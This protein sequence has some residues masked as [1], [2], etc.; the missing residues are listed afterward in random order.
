L[1]SAGR[2]WDICGHT[3]IALLGVEISTILLSYAV[4]FLECYGTERVFD[5]HLLSRY[6]GRSIGIYPGPLALARA[7]LAVQL[8]DKARAESLLRAQI[9]DADIDSYVDVVRRL[10]KEL[11]VSLE[12]ATKL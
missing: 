2:L 8:G 12:P 5:D 9:E 3:D 11:D 7:T 6:D 1:A 10:A 4:P